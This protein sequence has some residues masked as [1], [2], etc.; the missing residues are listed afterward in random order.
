MALCRCK[1]SI[2]YWKPRSGPSYCKG[3]SLFKI[4]LFTLAVLLF[5]F[6]IHLKRGNCPQTKIL[7]PGQHLWPK[8]CWWKT[9]LS[10]SISGTLLAKSGY[11]TLFLS[12]W[13][14][15]RWVD[16]SQPCSHCGCIWISWE[17]GSSLGFT[18]SDFY[19]RSS[20]AWPHF[21]T[22]MQPLPF[23]CMTSQM[24]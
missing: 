15:S 20:K 6:L 4:T 17:L 21:T 19:L 13:V 7:I 11:A 8:W 12:E 9:R 14:L 3:Y 23:W 18:A 2:F 24:T 1:P 10:S 16:L 22:E 5:L